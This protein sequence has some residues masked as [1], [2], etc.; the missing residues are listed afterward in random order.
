MPDNFAVLCACL[1]SE[2]KIS[3]PLSEEQL[4]ELLVWLRTTRDD[5]KSLFYAVAYQY[6][7]DHDEN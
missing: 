4:Q 3:T 5:N 2:A 7:C 1:E 6:A